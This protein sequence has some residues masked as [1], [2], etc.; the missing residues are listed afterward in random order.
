TGTTW[1]Q[2]RSLPLWAC[3]DATGRLRVAL[4]IELFGQTGPPH[5]REMP[6]KQFTNLARRYE[7]SVGVAVRPCGEWA[8]ELAPEYIAGLR[9]G[10]SVDG[11]TEARRPRTHGTNVNPS[12]EG[13][14]P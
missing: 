1:E 5:L 8:V 11:L 10:P 6:R 3:L 14:S 4:R 2:V 12:T 13:E 9:Q 7:V